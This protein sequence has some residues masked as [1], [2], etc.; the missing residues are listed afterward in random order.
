MV[1]LNVKLCI[2]N[3]AVVNAIKLCFVNT[4]HPVNNKCKDYCFH[5]VRLNI[6]KTV[7]RSKNF[8][9]G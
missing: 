4:A 6:S 5:F 1:V 9:S 3:A 8:G 7:V 2:T